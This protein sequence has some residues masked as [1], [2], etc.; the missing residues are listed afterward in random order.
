MKLQTVRHHP[1]PTNDK[2]LHAPRPHAQH[3]PEPA[4]SL[5]IP[6]L[7]DGTPLDCRVYHPASLSPN[8][9]APRWTSHAAII[10]HPYGP[11]GGSYDDPV[12]EEVVSV[13]LRRGF[14]VV[15]F[16][17]RYVKDLSIGRV[18]LQARFEPSPAFLDMKTADPVRSG[19]GTSAGRTSWTSKPEQEDYLSVIGFVVHYVYHLDPFPTPDADSLLSESKVDRDTEQL[20]PCLIMGGY[21]F[22]SIITTCLPPLTDIL[23]VFDTPAAGSAPAHIRLRA[24]H[25]A[26]QQNDILGETRKAIVD[27]RRSRERAGAHLRIGGDEEGQDGSP[28][29]S[30]D[31]ERRSFSLEAEEKLRKS[32]HELF[33]RGK[34]EHDHQRSPGARDSVASQGRDQAKAECLRPVI[35]LTLPRPAYLLVSP[36]QGIALHLF[37]AMSW[38]STRSAWAATSTSA[39]QKMLRNPTLAVYGDCD[40]FISPP[41]MRTW[42]SELARRERSQFHASEVSTAGHF[43]IEEG[44]MVRL[45]EIVDDFAHRL[46]G[47]TSP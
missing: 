39:E 3:A 16:N 32:M 26:A 4:I 28:K 36:I 35:G 13:L 14:L 46:T 8:P 22:G 20:P 33:R 40:A 41:K 17:F 24:E 18:G 7:H 43:W 37:N 42:T 5:T 21:S 6:S 19:S 9:R 15:T 29:R 45:K 2:Q 23:H 1:P 10:A 31:G 27:H 12:V 47:E 25:L 34:V 44:V 11:L 38:L 30:G